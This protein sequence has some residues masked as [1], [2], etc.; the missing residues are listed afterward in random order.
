MKKA[1]IAVTAVLLALLV[2]AGVYILIDRSRFE[3][4]LQDGV[5]EYRGYTR[6]NIQKHVYFLP[7]DAADFGDAIDFSAATDAGLFSVTG[8]IQPMGD[9]GSSD[10]FLGSIMVSAYPPAMEPGNESFSASVTGDSI[11]ISRMQALD[12]GSYKG[13]SYWLIMSA[14][15]PDIFAVMIH[16]D[17]QLIG[18]AYPG[19][20][21]EEAWASY[22]AYLAWFSGVK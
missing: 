6:V 11:H 22:K 15:D 14:E 8:V 10:S 3:D 17:G 16:Q 4:F 2:A 19:N 5:Q 13:I 9:G 12:G 7:D 18:T 20:T 21:P 1:F